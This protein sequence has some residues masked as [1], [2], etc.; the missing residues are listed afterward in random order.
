M[1]YQQRDKEIIDYE[2]FELPGVRPY[3]G[4][5]MFR[6]PRPTSDTYIACVGAAQTFGCF[7]EKPFPVLLTE[8]LGVETLNLGSG[9]ASPTFHNS[10]SAVM[11][12]INQA[13]L[14]IVQVLSGRSQSNSMFR[15]THH[16]ME[17]ER[18]ADGLRMTAEEFFE[19]LLKTAPE[20]VPL[21]VRETRQN[22]VRD[23]LRLLQDICRPKI[24]FWFSARTPEYAEEYPLPIWKLWG[25][26]PQFVN[27]EMI[28]QIKRYADEYVECVSDRGLPQPLIGKDGKPAWV[29]HSY[30][31]VKEKVT[32]ESY[33][34]YYPS[35][36]MHEEA[37]I[38]LE[39]VCRK[40]L[41]LRSGE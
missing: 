24:L 9:G 34:R 11:R 25:A 5:G 38:L 40:L 41:Y 26:F 3:P 18:V 2:M 15:L 29:R 28:N 36:E 8:R 12:H 14:V 30:K 17:G 19:G 31:L 21:I 10:N 4:D 13:S 33:N 37:A 20:S 27:R 23:M 7:C 1:G 32:V 16:G 6:A 35:P 39:P 22:Y